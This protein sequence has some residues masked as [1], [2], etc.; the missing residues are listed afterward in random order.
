VKRTRKQRKGERSQNRHRLIAQ[1]RSKQGRRKR[2]RWRQE[3]RMEQKPWSI[4][5]GTDRHRYDGN[6]IIATNRHGCK[7]V[8]LK[9]TDARN[10]KT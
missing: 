6:V 8:G 4:G 5:I 7:M 1:A 10:L 2:G 3:N 9:E